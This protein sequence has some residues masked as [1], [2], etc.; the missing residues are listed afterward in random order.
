MKPNIFRFKFF[1]VF[2][3]FFGLD[4]AQIKISFFLTEELSNRNVMVF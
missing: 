4:P 2:V 3:H 1:H